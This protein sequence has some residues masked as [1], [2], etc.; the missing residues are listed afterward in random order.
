MSPRDMKL[1]SL[2]QITRR[3]QRYAF[4]LIELLIVMG[5]IA[6]LMAILLPALACEDIAI[7]GW[8]CV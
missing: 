7:G 1:T 6:I 2:S 3:C 4:T 5:I 8:L